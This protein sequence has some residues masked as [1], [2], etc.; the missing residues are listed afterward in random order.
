MSSAVA[1]YRRGS[2]RAL[3][4]LRAVLLAG[5][6]AGTTLL[7]GC[8]SDDARSPADTPATTGRPRLAIFAVDGATFAVIDPLLAQGRLPNLA[9]LIARGSRNELRSSPESSLSPVLWT[10]VATGVGMAEHGI[11]DFT[12]RDGD[13]LR[14]YASTDRRVAALWNM[15][16]ARGG[17][18]G[19]VGWWNTWPAEAVQGYIVS[20]R[21][22][23]S[24]YGARVP[25]ADESAVTFPPELAEELRRFA[26]DPDG[27]TRAELERLGEFDDAEWQELLRAGAQH[28][29]A[30]TGHGLMAL[31]Y[32]LRAQASFAGAAQYLL[33][34]RPQPDVFTVFLELPD[35]VG[36]HFW[37]AYEPD[38][39]L[40]GPAAVEPEWRQRWS[41]IVPASYE[42]VD[43]VLG[44]LLARMDPDTNVLVV[45]DHGMR[46]SGGYG[47]SRRR[48]DRVGHSGTHDPDGILIAAGP[49]FVAGAQSQAT[50]HDVLPTVLAAL[51]LPATTQGQGRVLSALLVPEVLARHR[52]LPAQHDAHAGARTV[53]DVPG[54]DA[55][56][57]RHLEAIGYLDAAGT[58]PSPPAETDR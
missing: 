44:A 27:I 35:R 47:G 1:A 17:S 46:S 40:D 26:L 30:V 43:E 9:A 19:S 22:A 57:L 58:A 49:A 23:H 34:T 36:H 7:S 11:L 42:L 12:Q 15:I 56:F 51:E 3:S 32:G 21:F 48:L 24:L 45:S 38:K 53:P 5:L 6:A 14:I 39:V 37:H 31:K 55:D 2:G 41:R 33:E 18:V 10:T 29:V 16:S 28:G 25:I 8:G 54:L 4:A 13:T 52:A 20:D 50:L